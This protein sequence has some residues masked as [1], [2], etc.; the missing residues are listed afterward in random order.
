M[1]TNTLNI[2]ALVL[3]LAGMARSQ[4]VV[5]LPI[6]IA[7]AGTKVD[8]V[9]EGLSY[10]EGPAFDSAGNLFFSE[11]PDVNTGRIWKVTPAGVATV[12]KDPSRGSNGLEFD[13]QGRLNICMLDSVLRMERNGSV[14]V[15]ASRS[16][17]LTLGR[18]NDLS[19]SSTGAMFFTNLSGNT[20]FFRTPA[21]QI[22]TRTFNGVNGVE[23][24]EEKGIVFIASGGL[25]KCRVD[26]AT[27]VVSAC[28]SFA[29]GTDG[30]T[31]DINGNVY[32]AS[33]GDGRIFVHDSTGTQLGF[34]SI[35]AKEISGKRFTSGNAGNASNCHFGGPDRKTLYITGDGGCYKVLLKV[36]GRILPTAT[37]IT[38]FKLRSVN[39]RSVNKVH[40]GTFLDV[41]GRWLW[42]PAKRIPVLLLRNE[43]NF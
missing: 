2:A 19:I 16:A 6:E 17:S 31:T 1:L 33:W 10:S 42:N 21:G 36:P 12:Y 7:A 11:D 35:A 4:H 38:R 26:N 41:R 24:I 30:L 9:L 5:S 27:G 40:S 20:L 39:T 25:Q 28:A 18:V 23:W 37:A 32:R 13:L 8:S 14:T 3:C 34:I 22:T 29:G 43:L 15:L